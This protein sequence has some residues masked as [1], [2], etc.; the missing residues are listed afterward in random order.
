MGR[1]EKMVQNAIDV[2]RKVIIKLYVL[3]IHYGTPFTRLVILP[4]SAL[5]LNLRQKLRIAT[6]PTW[7]SS[8]V[9]MGFWGRGSLA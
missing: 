8:F 4:Q 6:P 3:M 2:D 7:K 9:D 5:S 1:R